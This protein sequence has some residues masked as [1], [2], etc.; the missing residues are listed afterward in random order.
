MDI[1][2]PSNHVIYDTLGPM[3]PAA[4]GP[5][6]GPWAHGPKCIVDNMV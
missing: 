2:V 3:G 5:G 4:P 6:P 1:Y